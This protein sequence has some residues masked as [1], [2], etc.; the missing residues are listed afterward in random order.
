[1]RKIW[2]VS[3]MALA[4]IAAASATAQ[5]NSPQSA[6]EVLKRANAASSELEQLRQNL[7]SPDQ[8]V[9]VSTFQA[10]IESNNPSLKEVAISEAFA[11][12][13]EAMKTMAF[14]AAAGVTCPRIFGPRVA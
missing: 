13:D 8:S 7:R 2:I 9:R 11:S 4:T 6:G 1:M 10:M 3:L 5:T 14:R 12:L